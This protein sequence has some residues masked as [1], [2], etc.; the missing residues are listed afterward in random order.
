MIVK[1]DGGS[2]LNYKD[3]PWPPQPQPSR[4]IRLL[5]NTSSQSLTHTKY[6]SEH[7]KNILLSPLCIALCNEQSYF[8]YSVV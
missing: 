8:R 1:T 3:R 2:Y 4:H 6:I 5:Q 7:F